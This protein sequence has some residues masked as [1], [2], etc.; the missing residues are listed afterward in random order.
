MGEFYHEVSF[1]VKLLNHVWISTG[2]CLHS[3]RYVARVTSYVLRTMYDIIVLEDS[4][5]NLHCRSYLSFHEENLSKL[6][7]S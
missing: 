2:Q 1:F 6:S 5:I 7:L 4:I 3:H